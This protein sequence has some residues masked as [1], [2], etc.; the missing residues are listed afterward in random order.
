M[1]GGNVIVAQQDSCHTIICHSQINHHTASFD[2]L[3]VW[4][5]TQ[6]TMRMLYYPDTLISDCT[7][8][9]YPYS[10]NNSKFQLIMK[11]PN[12]FNGSTLIE[13]ESSVNAHGRMSIVDMMG[14]IYTAKEVEIHAG[15]SQY[16]INIQKGG[17][18]FIL[19]ECEN[20]RATQKLIALSGGSGARNCSID[21]AGVQAKWKNDLTLR[22]AMPL[23]E[24][25]IVRC[26]AYYTVDAHP[27]RIMRTVQIDNGSDYHLIFDCFQNIGCDDFSLANCEVQIFD[28]YP[29][30]PPTYPPHLC[31][32]VFFSDSTFISTPA[33][34]YMESDAFS[35]SGEYNYRIEPVTEYDYKLYICP[36]DQDISE[37]THYL[38]LTLGDCDGFSLI[39]E[40][41]QDVLLMVNVIVIRRW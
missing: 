7:T 26:Y 11:G 41:M 35:Y 19:V 10:W 31:Y 16:S 36:I 29:S 18:Y 5:V 38:W 15:V 28:D 30:D 32:N 27:V 13:V 4:N 2:S 3:M 14:N 6:N 34:F 25:D 24:G 21:C 23:S 12:P 1:E 9:I 40:S 39:Q 33:D 22:S 37:T 8:G 17:I 20:Q